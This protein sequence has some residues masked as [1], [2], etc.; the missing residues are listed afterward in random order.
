MA[1]ALSFAPEFFWGDGSIA[2]DDLQRS[3]QPTCVYQAILSL[4]DDTWAGLA[5][6]V[7]DC[8]PDDLDPETVLSKVQETDTCRNLD[9]PVEVFVDSDGFYTLLIHEPVTEGT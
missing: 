8:E 4:P 5:R 2:P 3:D 6:D 7:F 1:Y 9:S